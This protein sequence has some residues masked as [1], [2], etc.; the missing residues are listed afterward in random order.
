VMGSHGAALLDNVVIDSGA[1]IGRD[2]DCF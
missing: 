2:H 1:P